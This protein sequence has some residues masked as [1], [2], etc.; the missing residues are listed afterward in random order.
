MLE[1]YSL[2]RE[3]GSHSKHFQKRMDGGGGGG[4]SSSCLMGFEENVCGGMSSPMMM[5]MPVTTNYNNFS[6]NPNTSTRTTTPNQRCYY[7]DKNIIDS[8]SGSMKAKIMSHPLYPRLLAA[9]ITCHKIGAPPEVVAKLEEAYAAGE[10]MHHRT[11][12]KLCFGQ[13][14]TLDQ[15]MEAYCEMLTKYE[16]ELT[17]PFKETMIFLS[18]MEGQ[19]QALT[20]SSSN[21]GYQGAA[22]L[23]G[24]SE[25]DVFANAN[26]IDPRDEDTELKFKLLHRY[27][28]S[29]VTLKQGFLKKKKKGKLP[30]E[31]RKQLLEWWTRHNR[32]PY[33]N[34]A[35][36][37][38]LAESTGLDQKQINN[39]FINQ[40]KRHWNPPE[41]PYFAAMDG[42]QAH[43]YL[44]GMLTNPY[45]MVCNPSLH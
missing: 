33:P 14:P 11:G 38:E 10:A 45:P 25:E 41:E 16:Q 12:R 39:W 29:L 2:K 34:E 22:D 43:Y 24:I 20:A 4:G 6:S 1:K 27:G 5:M 42:A 40:R 36:K 19:L 31:A 37:L 26:C 35:Q 28:G 15:F 23:N 9:Y 13:D 21:A 32:W 44:N 30:Q 18:G 8:D 3:R 7:M 17:K